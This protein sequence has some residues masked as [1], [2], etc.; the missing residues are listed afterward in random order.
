M[1]RPT[2]VA[3]RWRR[4][5]AARGGATAVE[6]ALVFPIV[7]VLTLGTF[8]LGLAVFE[9]HRAGEAMRGLARAFEIDPPITSYADLPVT[10]PGSA[11]CD[12]ARIS[13]AV[14]SVRAILPDFT[15]SNLQI[16]YRASGLD[17]ASTPG[18]V[19]PT[20]TVSAVGLRYQYMVLRRLVPGIGDS[21]T[22]PS[23]ATTRVVSTNLQ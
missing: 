20:V 10:C 21:L 3:S 6:F 13:A 19:T 15:A 18:V 9:F 17:D 4:F 16:V 14:T 8:E 11:A 22:L 7:V 23:F 12:G 2:S 5:G 1:S